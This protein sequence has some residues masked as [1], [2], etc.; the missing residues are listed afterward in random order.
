[1]RS[2]NEP[3]SCW[4]RLSTWPERRLREYRTVAG[5]FPRPAERQDAAA[6][7]AFSHPLCAA[8]TTFLPSQPLPDSYLTAIAF[9]FVSFLTKVFTSVSAL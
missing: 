5:G 7:V 8:G 2:A 1:M 9:I 6:A 4:P 3:T